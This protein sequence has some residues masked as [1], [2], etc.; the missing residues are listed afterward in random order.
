[1]KAADLRLHFYDNGDGDARGDDCYRPLPLRAEFRS[2]WGGTR[3]PAAL[4][5]K[6]RTRSGTHRY[7]WFS[8]TGP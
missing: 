4:W 5:G 2:Y 7:I 1:M 3:N 6:L 8:Q